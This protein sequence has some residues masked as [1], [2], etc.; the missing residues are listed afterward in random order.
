MKY[1][2]KFNTIFI[3]LIL[4][5]IN[6]NI[7]SAQTFVAATTPD[8]QA[9]A[10]QQ[11]VRNTGSYSV[12]YE[13]NNLHVIVWDGDT[14]GLAWYNS[15][16]D[17]GNMPLDGNYLGQI[18]D[19][20]IA[21]FAMTNSN[22][23]DVVYAFIIYI[24]NGDVYYEDWE[25]NKGIWTINVPANQITTSGLCSTPNVDVDNND[26]GAVWQEGLDIMLFKSN[27]MV[28][29]NYLITTLH[30]GAT[31][32]TFQTPD[33]GVINNF[34]NIV[35]ILNSHVG[36]NL[37]VDHIPPMGGAPTTDDFYLLSS[38]LAYQLGKPR[39]ALPNTPIS[40]GTYIYYDNYEVV[41]SKTWTDGSE[42]LGFNKYQST[43]TGPTKL[44]T[45]L[46]AYGNFE[47]VV[48]Y[49]KQ[50]NLIAAWIYDNVFLPS[51]GSGVVLPTGGREFIQT[52]LNINGGSPLNPSTFLMVNYQ[53]ARNCFGTSV[54]GRFAKWNRVLY[55]AFG[56][57]S[58]EI[59][60]KTSPY[61]ASSVRVGKFEQNPLF[62]PNP[63]N[64]Q[65]YINLPEN[66]ESCSIAIYDIT[67][68]ILISKSINTISYI[69]N[70][71]NLEGG[72]YFIR[73]TG[74]NISKLE[75]LIVN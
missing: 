13:N 38:G 37:R 14:P 3:A 1:F 4:A 33:I 58:N 40:A 31:N 48:T 47:P 75:K 9:A 11:N 46:N 7:S 16:G 35:Y 15:N 60:Y 53:Y 28:P 71:D 32:D 61:G 56:E 51:G 72:V 6:I 52:N 18:E 10:G 59:F 21:L 42:I 49:T 69:L 50:N 74:P 63:A 26:L 17:Q 45:K 57:F 70:L 67:G 23:D 66:T 20:D 62:Y 64:N 43:I 12:E 73:F 22:N 27:M 30:S 39:I 34:Y 29:Q 54:S 2:Y 19:P 8:S 44:N 68:K 36:I 25:Y 24:I 41:I 5:L 55:A 65:L